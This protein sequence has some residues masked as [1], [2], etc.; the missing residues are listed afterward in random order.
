MQGRNLN[1]VVDE[2][3][4]TQEKKLRTRTHRIHQMLQND[5][6]SMKAPQNFRVKRRIGHELTDLVNELDIMPDVTSNIKCI[7]MRNG[8]L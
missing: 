1:E 8:H 7:L 2:I 4:G 3:L 6:L 5:K